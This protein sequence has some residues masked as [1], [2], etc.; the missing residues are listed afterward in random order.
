MSPQATF[1]WLVTHLFGPQEGNKLNVRSF[2]VNPRYQG[3]LHYQGTVW[4]TLTAD[5]GE[6]FHPVGN[7]LY[8]LY[9]FRPLELW[10]EFRATPGV[11][12]RMVVYE[13]RAG[14]NDRVAFHKTY[15]QAELQTEI[16]IPPR[17]PQGQL[18]ISFEVRGKGKFTIGNIHFR[19]TRLGSGEFLPG[20]ERLINADRGEL[21]WYFN[22]GNLQ[23]PLNIYFSGYRAREGFE[24]Y[25][26]MKGLHHPFL[27]ITD[28]RLEGGGFYLQSPA[29]EQQLCQK[30]RTIL[31]WLGFTEREVTFAGL[32]MGTAGALYYGSFFQPHAIVL[33]KPLMRLGQVAKNEQSRFNTFATSLDVARL[34]ED[35]TGPYPDDATLLAALDQ[36]MAKRLAQADLTQTK[37]IV[38]YM[39][40]D[41]YD[42]QGFATLVSYLNQQPHFPYLIHHGFEGHHIDQPAA[43]N[44]WFIRQY[45][46]MLERDFGGD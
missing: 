5:F 35:Q 25:Y 7:F 43:A 32:S 29:V 27:L 14:V 20:G 24:G 15:S 30:I 46:A 13:L 42:D 40:Q 44:G 36:R 9:E 8:S 31:A 10:P 38:A 2:Q 37:F 22:P 18:A 19:W 28:T 6:E 39:R 33:G 21:H 41:D 45:Q 34:F 16:V 1:D 12:V 17:T 23:P 3:T 4:L 11:E 26:M